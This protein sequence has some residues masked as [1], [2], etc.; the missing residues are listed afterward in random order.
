MPELFRVYLK[1]ANAPGQRAFS[2]CAHLCRAWVRPESDRRSVCSAACGWLEAHARVVVG[3]CKDDA[4][5]VICD[6][7]GFCLA[8]AQTLCNQIGRV[9]HTPGNLTDLSETPDFPLSALDTVMADTP[10][11]CA[12]SFHVGFGIEEPPDEPGTRAGNRDACWIIVNSQINQEFTFIS[13]VLAW[14]ES[15][16]KMDLL[17]MISL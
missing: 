14:M 9:V 6:A 2:R 10:A 3:V 17:H 13:C 15:S 7:D 16:G 5:A 12:M 8:H 4:A 11:A 1:T